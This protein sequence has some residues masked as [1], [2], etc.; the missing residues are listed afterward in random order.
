[1]RE[2][3]ARVMV[4]EETAENFLRGLGVLEAEE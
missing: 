4:S 2:L 1:M 3:Y